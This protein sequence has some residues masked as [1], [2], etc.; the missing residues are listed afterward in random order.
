MTY[1][2]QNLG[3]CVQG[4]CAPGCYPGVDHHGHIHDR[5]PSLRKFP[6]ILVPPGAVQ[7]HTFE[8]VKEKMCH[9]SSESTGNLHR[10]L[11]HKYY[12]VYQNSPAQDL[13]LPSPK[14]ERHLSAVKRK[15]HLRTVD[16]ICYFQAISHIIPNLDLIPLPPILL[17]FTPN[18]L[19][20][21]QSLYSICCQSEQF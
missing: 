2:Y 12:G 5:K 17:K 7:T 4:A 13:F 16:S 8:Q 19:T 18:T 20:V 10:N 11:K 1:L 14:L 21:T 6:P 15:F 9:K 3:F